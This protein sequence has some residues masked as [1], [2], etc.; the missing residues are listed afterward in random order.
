MQLWRWCP[1]LYSSA[2]AIYPE[3]SG[4]PR[5]RAGG[6]RFMRARIFSAIAVAAVAGLAF[7]GQ[8]LSGEEVL[9]RSCAL[10]Q[11][12][13]DYKCLA[14]LEVHHPRIHVGKRRFRVFVKLPDKVR[15]ESGGQIVVVPRGVFLL[16]KPEKLLGD[17]VEVALIGASEVGGRPVYCLKLKRP[18]DR[19]FVRL[20]VWG[21]TWTFKRTEFFI[22]N[23]LQLRLDWQHTK[24]GRFWMPSLVEFTFQIQDEGGPSQGKGYLRLWGYQ[25]NCGLPDSLFEEKAGR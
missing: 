25:V 11:G 24:V 10:Y 13:R 15:V 20:Y 21:D 6:W 7:G 9:R 3:R 1:V 8:H 18:K 2:V 4:L 12:L 19:R 16:G 17:G 23:Q 14:E 22:G 5:S